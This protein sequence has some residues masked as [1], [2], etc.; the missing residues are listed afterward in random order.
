[1]KAGIIH[2]KYS[3]ILI[4]GMCL[5]CND[6]LELNPYGV[7]SEGTFWRDENDALLALT[8]VYNNQSASNE[9]DF[10]SSTFVLF[11]DQK[12]DNAYASNDVREFIVDGQLNPDN[13]IV[14]DTWTLSYS[15]VARANY[16]L[17][18]VDKVSNMD[19]N[20]KNVM[21]AE[22]RFI[23]A[24]YYFF[25]SQYWGGVPLVTKVLSVPEAN[26]ISISPKE[27]IVS[28]VLKELSEVAEILPA[29]RPDSERGRVTKAA[30]LAFKGRLLMSEKRWSEAA[31][32]YKSIMDLGIY[33]IDPS[34]Q[35]IFLENGE[36]SKEIIYSVQYLG[37]NNGN[38]IPYRYNTFSMGGQSQVTPL[39]DLVQAYE[40]ID[41]RTID[42]SPLY[43]PGNPYIKAGE[44]YRDPR[45]YYT[46]LLPNVSTL[47]DGSLYVTHPDSIDSRDAL[48]K[49][50]WTGY[51]LLKFID[52]SF[53]GNLSAYGGDVPLV[54]YAEVLLS[55][56]ESKLETGDLITQEL[57]DQTI[58]KVRGRESVKMPAVT[59][60]NRDELRT[61][62]RRERRVELAME[63][64]R[65]WDI[66]RW[67]IAETVLNR[68]IYGA[69]VADGPGGKYVT[70]QNGYYYVYER[71]FKSHHYLWPI[72]QSE[73]DINSNLGQNPGY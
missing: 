66:C 3:F 71:K 73:R 67:G 49:F 15:K 50:S 32:T 59:E 72:P 46:I 62:L 38:N 51:G 29:A 27:E 45:L 1:M 18:N 22:A 9:A 42:E 24:A 7:I 16:F 70:D 69:K 54:R 10:F 11:G 28:F 20:V 34:Y 68:K 63:G 65:N 17:D 41:G 53:S 2:I 60:T 35:D 31:A 4:I 43:D 52:Y 30:A 14:R 25:M 13:P 12:S 56:L 55:Y 44:R 33:I 58:N 57:L 37:P 36:K 61:V 23:R 48:P 8:G 19:E 21:K 40:C 6:I 39:N 5:S 64:I 26:S 47:K